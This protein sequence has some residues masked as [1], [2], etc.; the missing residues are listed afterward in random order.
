MEEP[1]LI[2][3]TRQHPQAWIPSEPNLQPKRGADVGGKATPIRSV[4]AGP[5]FFECWI[6]EGSPNVKKLIDMS[7]AKEGPKGRG[8]PLA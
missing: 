6:E 5:L 1:A 2:N 8:M 3:H 7:M 4:E